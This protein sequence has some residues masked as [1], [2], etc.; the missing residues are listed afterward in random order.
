MAS[1][2]EVDFRVG[3]FGLLDILDRS[4]D[5]LSVWNIPLYGCMYIQ[6]NYT[7]SNP[8]WEILR[9]R[10]KHLRLY[11]LL[12]I[13]RMQIR[14]NFEITCKVMISTGAL[15][16]RRIK[17]LQGHTFEHYCQKVLVH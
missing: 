8:W 16:R 1:I 2:V 17:L 5:H 6:S 12:R 10:L 4:S 15:E 9:G 14:E 11:K 7:V 3:M 13:C